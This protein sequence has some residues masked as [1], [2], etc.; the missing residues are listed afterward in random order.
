MVKGSEVRENL[1]P[2]ELANH[3]GR[4]G[5]P[6]YIAYKGKVYDVTG[7]VLWSGGR[8][9]ALHE[10]GRDLTEALKSAPHGEEFIKRFPVV[11]Y[12]RAGEN[13]L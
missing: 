9:Q 2:E 1:T 3:D 12:L 10:A 5:K 11:G 13:D 4:E 8:H 7:S 6:A